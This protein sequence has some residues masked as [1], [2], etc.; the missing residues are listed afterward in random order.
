MYESWAATGI[1]KVRN[2]LMQEGIPW[3]SWKVLNVHGSKGITNKDGRSFDYLDYLH[4]RGEAVQSEGNVAISTENLT[5]V[6]LEDVQIGN[7]LDLE[8]ALKD[9]SIWQANSAQ[10]MNFGLTNFPGW[11]CDVHK[12]LYIHN[13]GVLWAGNCRFQ[14]LGNVYT[15]FEPLTGPVTCDGRLCF[16]PVDV[17]IE[18]HNPSPGKGFDIATQQLERASN[19]IVV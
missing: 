7:N 19:E 4:S 5:E 6:L 15:A 16:C 17:Q 1:Q 9:G 3:T 13:D 10:L 12:S 11:Q 2:V 14:N 18:K 8:V